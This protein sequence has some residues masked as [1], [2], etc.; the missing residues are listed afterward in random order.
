[1]FLKSFKYISKMEAGLIFVS[2]EDNLS[3]II[4]AITKQR[5]NYVGFFVNS[6]QQ[7]LTRVW[8]IDIFSASR[9][10]WLST[11]TFDA[12]TKNPL[13]SQIAIKK[14]KPIIT[15][16]HKVDIELT[17]KNIESFKLCICSALQDHQEL[18]VQM[19]VLK[20]FGHQCSNC[21][22]KTD[23]SD[24]CSKSAN[25]LVNTVFKNFKIYDNLKFDN[26]TIDADVYSYIKDYHLALIAYKSFTT[27][28]SGT[29]NIFSYL[30]ETE[31]FDKLE[32]LPNTNK[33]T[34]INVLTEYNKSKEIAINK[35]IQVFNDCIKDT[36]NFYNH[37]VI[38]STIPKNKDEKLLS[39]LNYN[40]EKLLNI[41]KR[42]LNDSTK[43]KRIGL[44]RDLQ[45]LLDDVNK[46][47]NKIN[48]QYDTDLKDLEI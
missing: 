38:A 40:F 19:S 31:Y 48:I 5:Y 35:L 24:W 20:L 23:C 4:K 17:T 37:T 28:P 25:D 34:N 21:E 29:P 45:N 1:M 9:P 46:A 36:T 43:S 11:N 32:L 30:N 16:D 3:K 47:R 27:L 2:T 7:N 15:K 41:T 33:N 44:E 42:L 18:N 8:L 13:V 39:K 6:E 14:L 12:I 26:F 22:V 10:D